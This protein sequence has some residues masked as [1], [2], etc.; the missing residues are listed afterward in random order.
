[1]KESNIVSRLP[2]GFGATRDGEKEECLVHKLQAT[3]L[4]EQA[5]VL[6]SQSTQTVQTTGNLNLIKVPEDEPASEFGQRITNFC[7]D[8][9]VFKVGTDNEGT[10]VVPFEQEDRAI[11]FTFKKCFL[12]RFFLF[13]TCFTTTLTIPTGTTITFAWFFG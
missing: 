9:P 3:T 5:A 13:Y 2:Q 10:R 7:G 12:W 8:Y 6:R 4:E 1:M 11:T